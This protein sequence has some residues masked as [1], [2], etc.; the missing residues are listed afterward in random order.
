MQKPYSILYLDDE[1]QNLLSFQALFRR[2]Y[3]VYTTTSAHEA[4]EILNSHEIQVIFSDQKMPDVSG[5]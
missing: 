1:E 2:T 4:V 5:V 3:N